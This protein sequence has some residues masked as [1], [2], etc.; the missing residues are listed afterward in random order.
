[1]ERFL[2]YVALL[3]ISYLH[4]NQ[5]SFSLLVNPF[6][7]TTSPIPERSL[8]KKPLHLLVAHPRSVHN[9]YQFLEGTSMLAHIAMHPEIFPPVWVM[10]YELWIIIDS[11]LTH[12]FIYSSKTFSWLQISENK[13]QTNGIATPC[14][15]CW[16]CSLPTVGQPF[17]ILILITNSMGITWCVIVWS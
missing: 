12:S 17:S 6:K 9:A 4:T 5:H 3:C 15:S 16:I 2:L 8:V 10:N 13:I 7:V 11:T 14:K 1:M